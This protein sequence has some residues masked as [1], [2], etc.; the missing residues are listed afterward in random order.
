MPDD[1][2][3]SR[4]ALLLPAAALGFAAALA[5]AILLRF[6]P[7]LY[8]F[9]PECPIH[10]YFHIL[11]PGCGGTRALAALLRGDPGEALRLNALT[12]LLTPLA[13]FYAAACY[14]PILTRAPL[15]LP[16][17]PRAAIY[18]ALAAAVFFTVE[19]NL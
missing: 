3:Q 19:R 9:Y 4:I 16:Q 12:T 15:H 10:H 8:S 7:G 14:R 5:V 17:P 18:A 11:C 13:V 6:P 1:A 2:A